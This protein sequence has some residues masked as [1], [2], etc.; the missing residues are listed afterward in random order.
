MHRE[1]FPLTDDV[2][3]STKTSMDVEFDPAKDELNIA[4]H[5]VSLS[6]GTAVF[7]DETHLL[8][9]SSRPIDGEDRFKLIGMVDGKLYTVVHVYR[10]NVVRFISVRRSNDGEERLYHRP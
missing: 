8:L 6:F 4:K 2:F 1:D 3:A 9:G 5:G 10:G 7:L